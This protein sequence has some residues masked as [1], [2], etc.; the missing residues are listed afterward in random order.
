MKRILA[1]ATSLFLVLG[2]ATASFAAEKPNVKAV[3]AK[4][5]QVKKAKKHHKAKKT[6]K[7]MTRKSTMPADGAKK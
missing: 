4:T 6:A 3:P 5:A 2:I 7:K 1:L